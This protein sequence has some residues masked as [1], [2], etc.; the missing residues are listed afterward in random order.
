MSWAVVRGEP[1]AAQLYLDSVL[2]AITGG[3]SQHP[4][5]VS[6]GALLFHCLRQTPDQLFMINGVTGQHFSA[7]EIL[8]LSVRV[9]RALRT[10]CGP[11]AA[12]AGGRI[13]AAVN[14]NERSL[15]VYLAAL[16][17]GLPLMVIHVGSS[18]YEMTHY[19]KL[20]E[21]LTVFCD[22]AVKEA[23]L[24]AAAEV[25]S[26]HPTPI[27]AVES[28]DFDQ[29]IAG[30]SDDIDSFTVTPT[31]PDHGI[32]LLSTSGSTGLPKSAIYTNRGTLAQIPMTWIYYEQFPRPTRLVLV[33]STPQWTTYTMMVL[34]AAV[35]GY[36]LLMPP[37]SP[38]YADVR[39]VVHTYKPTFS[40]LATPFTQGLVEVCEPEHLSSF[41]TVH[42]LGAQ[43]TSECYAMVKEK[44][45]PTCN[46]CD[47]YGLTETQGYVIMADPKG[48]RCATGKV[49]NI[50][51]YKLVNEDGE[52]VGADEEGELYIKCIS[53][54]K[55]YLKNNEFQNDFKD[56]WL[57]TGDMFVQDKDGNLYYRRRIK[58][59]FKYFSQWVS[60]EEV[61]RV[62]S[63]V[64]G[65]RQLV[66]CSSERGPAAVV[67]LMND[68]DPEQVKREIHAVVNS[69]LNETKQLRGGVF[70]VQDAE[71][72]RTH[73]GKIKRAG[74]QQLV[75]SLIRRGSAA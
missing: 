67:V 70:V 40:M 55:G 66:V 73:S 41:E 21:P 15:A 62:A 12:A 13:L 63:T 1:A 37:P 5:D 53:F 35:Y 71:L 48:P 51:D 30:H 44:F 68:A 39:H 7:G 11:A 6:A 14:N 26:E 50:F 59:T 4:S 27:V 18:Q 56:G 47:G 58:F 2:A 54:V 34:G 45:A 20:G 69:T 43:I 8:A 64:P 72:P 25:D 75:A 10:R 49:I 28:E 29:F 60:P 46:I 23:F 32:L 57:Q 3:G 65:V 42:M 24:A 38:T 9:A 61:E 22:A 52:V 19:L 17:T 74:V 33:M 36:A 16:L 31:G